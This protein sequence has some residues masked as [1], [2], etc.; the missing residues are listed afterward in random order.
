MEKFIFDDNTKLL[1]IK[2][3]CILVEHEKKVFKTKLDDSF[4]E[5]LR[6]IC[7]KHYIFESNL[8]SKS[9]L[10]FLERKLI[11]KKMSPILGKYIGTKYEKLQI[12]LEN[13]LSDGDKIDYIK[14]NS[15]KKVLFVGAGGICTAMID[16]LISTGII[17]FGIVDF[18][19]VDITNFNRQ[20]KYNE[21]DIGISKIAQLQKNLNIQY[22]NLIITPYEQKI[23]STLELEKI[24]KD[25]NPSFVICAADTPILLIQKYVAE[26]CY[27]YNVPCIFGGVGQKFGTV[28]PLLYNKKGFCKYLKEIEKILNSVVS[29]FPCKGSFSITNSLISNYMAKDVI[30]YLMG[31]KERVKS[32]N[33]KCELN[34]DKDE[35]YEKEKY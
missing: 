11:I 20:F 13:I 3:S 29:I 27:N 10:K 33:K 22:K 18:D 31:K 1:F 21:T 4:Y 5:K 12:Y 32:L 35:F 30:F 24:I 9:E 34:F 19:V 15:E 14:K 28:G 8:F 23:T 25:Y 17:Q 6:N 16:Y 26:A 2:E 7:E